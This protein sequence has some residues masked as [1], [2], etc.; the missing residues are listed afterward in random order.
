MTVEPTR[1]AVVGGG[2]AAVG[3]VLGLSATGRRIHTTLIDHPSAPTSPLEPTTELAG[4]SSQTHEDA[5]FVRRLRELIGRKFPPPKSHFGQQPVTIDV[6]DWGPIWNSTMGAGLTRYWGGS[7][8]PWPDVE[9][10]AWPVDA[11]G[12]RPHY[13]AIVAHIG[14]AGADDPLSALWGHGLA[15]RPPIERPSVF[16]RLTNVVN[17][18]ADA[19]TE[20]YHIVA[21]T[22]RL[23]VET[24]HSDENR[25]R[26][27]G[28]CMSGCR[29]GAIY[30]ADRSIAR[31]RAE[32]LIDCDVIGHVLA[33]D[34]DSRTIT[35]QH[36]GRHEVLG[37]FRHIFLAAGC[38]GSTGILLRSI[39]S[40]SPA[41]MQDN[42]LYTFP[43]IDFGRQQQPA[44]T[45]DYFALTNMFLAC[46][47]TDARNR[48]ALVQLYPFF[49]LL[50]KFYLPS[51]VWPAA[52]P[53]G[54]LARGRVLIARLY[55]PGHLSQ[56]YRVSLDRGG[57]P[58]LALEDAG[59]SLSDI[60]ALWRDIRRSLNR[61]GFRVPR[62]L[63]IRHKTSSHY[64]GTFPFGRG[65]VGPDGTVAPGV[66][67]CDSAAFPESS[68]FSPTLTIMAHAHRVAA[69][70]AG[71]LEAK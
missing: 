5:A 20:G 66:Y 37:P 58:V 70:V 51:H 6:D 7:A 29:Y 34:R 71:G 45:R 18:G 16:D 23:A 61:G 50:W 1:V 3:V 21:G 40:T 54:R 13:Q 41:Q 8:L 63:R 11:S 43:I 47:P 39:Q 35:V 28:A 46:L 68:A 17:H 64:A 15:S 12:L 9:F 10:D 31:F 69:S 42:A 56:R 2:A 59:T 27:V 48:A 4:S 55:T 25:C 19:D 26:F 32:G 33:V 44:R 49:D 38:L 22:G 24:G 30:S 52:A 57:N 60:P 36:G 62:H 67:L 14:V 65:P 53:L